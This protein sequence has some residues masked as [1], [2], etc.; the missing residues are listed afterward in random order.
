MQKSIFHIPKM[1]CPSEENMIRAKLDG[2]TQIA[3]LDFDIPNRTLHVFHTGA[4]DFIE[5]SIK[6]L[7]P[8]LDEDDILRVAGRLQESV[9][10][11]FPIILP[12]K[13][14]RLVRLLI[15]KFHE[16]YNHAGMSQTHH[17]LRKRVWIIHGGASCR[18]VI[19]KCAPCVR[20]WEETRD[21]NHGATS[22]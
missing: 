15:Q 11:A 22:G 9:E 21:S 4:I 13:K 5:S 18:S 16:D 19:R 3:H 10:A 7:N 2:I 17:E 12:D 1:D 8:I 14:E 6:D 20:M